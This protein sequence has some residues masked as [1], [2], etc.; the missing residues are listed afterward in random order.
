[1]VEKD[2]IQ[3]ISS[4]LGSKSEKLFNSGLSSIYKNPSSINIPTIQSVAASVLG[5]KSNSD[6]KNY[7]Q[8]EVDEIIENVIFEK[9]KKI[10]NENKR[11]SEVLKSEVMV[12]SEKNNANN[13]T[14]LNEQITSLKNNNQKFL[15]TLN[16]NFTDQ[17][18]QIRNSNSSILNKQLVSFKKEIDEIKNSYAAENTEAIKNNSKIFSDIESEYRE[19]LDL[20]VNNAKDILTDASTAVLTTSFKEEKQARFDSLRW[21]LAAF[22]FVVLVMLSVPVLLYIYGNIQI[23]NWA[24]NP[25]LFVF[26]LA[27][28]AALEWPLIWVASLLSKRMQLQQRVYEEY[29]H[30]YAAALSYSALRKDI[31]NMGKDCQDIANSTELKGFTDKLVEAVY[32]NPSAVFDKIVESGSPSESIVKI[33]E[34]LGPDRVKQALAEI[35]DKFVKK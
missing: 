8:K 10:E 21:S 18:E 13:R 25:L 16:Q 11:N 2:N 19:R 1:M 22:C 35:G 29:S 20:L 34:K 9:L 30:K 4:A 17:V 32:L 6:F 23:E 33:I 24:Q 26:S 12:Q 5:G 3:S 27:K 7:D 14:L 31:K 15:D 28:A